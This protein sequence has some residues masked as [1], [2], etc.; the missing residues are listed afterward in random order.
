MGCQ[1]HRIGVD[2]VIGQAPVRVA[3]T[4]E[5]E[6]SVIRHAPM[7]DKLLSMIR[8]SASGMQGSTQK[9]HGLAPRSDYKNSK[10]INARRNVSEFGIRNLPHL[11]GPLKGQ[12]R[13]GQCQ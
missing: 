10:R 9:M 8:Y 7:I 12:R 6:I 3:A 11:A 2:R 13:H 4:S 1:R 5:M